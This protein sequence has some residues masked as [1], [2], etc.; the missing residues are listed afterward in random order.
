METLPYTVIKS[1][2]QYSKYCD[3]LEELVESDNTSSTIKDEIELLTLLIETYDETQN[4]FED[5]DP[6]Q[7]LKSLMKEQKMKAVDL[8]GL[9]QVSEG[10]VS[11][12]LHYKKGLS[13]ESIRVLAARFKLSQ[14]AFNRPYKLNLSSNN[15]PESTRTLRKNRKQAIV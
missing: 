11:D 8:A 6:I 2:T 9:L 12:I 7:L 4:S 14:E 1:E 10:L 3:R 5:A 15:P 13:K